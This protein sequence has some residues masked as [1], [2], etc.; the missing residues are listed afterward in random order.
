[1]EQTKTEK[2]AL[3]TYNRI[4]N[5]QHENGVMQ[6]GNKEIF[7]A[8][9]GHRSKW[10]YNPN[11]GPISQ[12]AETR[13]CAARMAAQQVNLNDMDRIFVYVGAGGGEE[14]IRQ[15][16]D[17]PAEKITYVLCSCNYGMKKDLIRRLGNAE[18]RI[19]ECECGGRDTMERIL[20]NLL[21]E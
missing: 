8:Q 4:G 21:E 5:G 1:M 17:I 6:A 14:A 13:E 9:N 3:V 11:S 2:I 18:A 10:A 15:T 16:R 20:E 7:I 19:R 12:A